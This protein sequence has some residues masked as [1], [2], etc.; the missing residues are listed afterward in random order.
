[1]SLLQGEAGKTRSDT[2]KF[3]QKFYGVG[4]CHRVKIVMESSVTAAE[5]IGMS[6]F[7]SEIAA[8]F[9]TKVTAEPEVGP[10][11]ADIGLIPASLK[12][13][14]FHVLCSIKTN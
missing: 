4:P 9:Q 6:A 1:M 7:D 5:K 12:D 10:S 14:S 3:L 8:V 11:A 2:E 13:C